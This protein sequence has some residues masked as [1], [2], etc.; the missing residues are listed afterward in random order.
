LAALWFDVEDLFVYAATT[1]R[2]SGIQ[3][4]AFEIYREVW[5][6]L[7]SEPGKVRFVRHHPISR[8]FVEIPWSQIDELFQRMSGGHGPA[9]PKPVYKK[10]STRL[11]AGLIERL[12]PRLQPTALNFVRLQREALM[13][14]VL[15]AWAVLRR[16]SLPFR[17][18]FNELTG[19]HGP[20]KAPPIEGEAKE[21]HFQPGDTLLA[22][23]SPWFI[24]HYGE[25]VQAAQA[26]G[27]RF[28]LLVYD[29]IPLRRP[30][31]CDRHLVKVFTEWFAA[32]LPHADKLFAISRYSADDLEFYAKQQKIELKSRVKP[33]PIAAGFGQT[34][35][36][37]PAERPIDLPEPG[38]YALIVSTIEARKNHMLLFRLWRRLVEDLPAD[39]VPTL[40]F[41]GR[42]GWLVD[43]FMKQ[44]DNANWLDGKIVLVDNPTDEALAHLY[45]GCRFTLF[46]SFYEGWGLPVTESLAFGKPALISDRTSLPEAGG[47]LARYFDP[48]NLH[49]AYAALRAVVDDDAAL[50]AWEAEVVRDF[51]PVA[52]SE[53]ADALLKGLAAK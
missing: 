4:L 49:E 2:P 41:A 27:A 28:A 25:L 39:R 32:V 52:W 43:D 22:L 18:V 1:K 34:P 12:P 24:A 19:K 17:Y 13:A 50:A 45:R 16:L 8:K 31:W 23:G 46:P 36:A 29:I 3:R 47:K 51:K 14:W 21:A 53:T 33:I 35:E 44:L 30:E 38:T 48:D 40:V 20:K 9:L 11:Y 10:T 26:E 6:R 42:V 7:G 37:N 15:L 5:E